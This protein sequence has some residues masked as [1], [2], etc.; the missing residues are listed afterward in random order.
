MEADAA[1]TQRWWTAYSADVAV[2][3]SS[4][5]RFDGT[6]TVS[7]T[8]IAGIVFYGSI[9]SSTLRGLQLSRL[10]PDAGEME[11]FPVWNQEHPPTDRQIRDRWAEAGLPSST[12]EHLLPE[13]LPRDQEESADAF[14]KRVAAYYSSAAVINGRPTRTIAENADVPKSTAARWVREARARGFLDP[15]TR[16]RGRP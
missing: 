6:A 9:N 12:P 4:I 15:T 5:T 2:Y 10:N 8:S 16:G 14:Y 11:G 13:F 1:E 7:I 3:W